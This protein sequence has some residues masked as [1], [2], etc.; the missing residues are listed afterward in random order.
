MRVV[1]GAAKGRRLDGPPGRTTRPM[2]DRAKEGLF[3]A[4]GP[5]IHGAHVLDLFAGSGSLGL[6]AL[7]RGAERA[8]F[9][10]RDRAAVDAL[11]RNVEAVGLGGDV[12]AGDVMDCLATT[13]ASFDL[14]FVDP[15]YDLS[16][17]SVREVL[18]ALER[19]L[20]PGALV[21]V[22][23]RAGEPCPETPGLPLEAERRYGT[24][25]LWRLRVPDSTETPDTEERDEEQ[26]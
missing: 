19:C 25:Q 13:S 7:S 17:P 2:T 14:A 9:V 11:R 8:T 24:T 12:V 1:A 22:H 18:E 26:R 15:P 23:R 6:E 10:E 3:S 5:E 4:I 21:I 20:R 16:L